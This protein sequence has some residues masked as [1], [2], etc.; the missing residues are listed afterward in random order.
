M[1]P[2]LENNTLAVGKMWGAGKYNWG[3][4]AQEGGLLEECRSGG[5][6]AR[7]LLWGTVQ[8]MGAL[9]CHCSLLTDRKSPKYKV[10]LHCT[11]NDQV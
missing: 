5:T 7:A 2:H 9:P 10:S 6:R 11:V 4:G 3:V 1:I 8:L